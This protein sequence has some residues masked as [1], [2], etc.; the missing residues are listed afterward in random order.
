MREIA[1]TH[2]RE[3]GVRHERE[4]EVRHERDRGETCVREMR[5]K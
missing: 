5:D 1:A 3:I 4:V 2:E